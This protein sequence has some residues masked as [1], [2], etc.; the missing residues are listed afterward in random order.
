[1]APEQLRNETVDARSDVFALGICLFEMLS[2]LRL[3]KRPTLRETMIA[4]IQE[5]AP[6]LTSV[7]QELPVELDAI[8]QR[9]LQKRAEDRYQSAGELQAALES[10][11][12]AR[13]EVGSARRVGGLMARL[14]PHQQDNDAQV[15]MSREATACFTAPLERTSP[16]AWLRKQSGGRALLLIAGVAGLLALL[17]FALRSPAP[18]APA[19]S[20][21]PIAAKA[22]P[23]T[24]EVPPAPAAP[25]PELAAPVAPEPSRPV[26]TA[27][28]RTKEA[29][30]DSAPRKRRRS[31]PGFVADPGF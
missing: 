7:V 9:A 5:P 3:H 20:A 30:V 21:A 15:D 27:S 4:V 14:Y 31:S 6:A 2:G 26:P 12:A 17:T 24:P 10:Y 13:G 22:A 28:P 25:A 29:P 19:S 1:M 8:V 18:A 11:L 16:L 23:A